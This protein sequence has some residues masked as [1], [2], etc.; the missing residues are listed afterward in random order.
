MASHGFFRPSRGR[1]RSIRVS[2]APFPAISPPALRRGGKGLKVA[3]IKEGFAQ[4]GEDTGF[5]PS[6]REVDRCVAGA[7]RKLETLGATVEEIALPMHLDAFHIWNGVVTEGAADF[8][9]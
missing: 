5:P 7:A 6:D 1:I 3:L 8:V 2:A 9:M 4:S